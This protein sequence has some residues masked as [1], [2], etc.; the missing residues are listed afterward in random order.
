MLTDHDREQLLKDL[1]MAPTDA[2]R[3]KWTPEPFVPL[4]LP[5]KVHEAL[6]RLRAER[7][8]EEIDPVGTAK[9]RAIEAKYELPGDFAPSQEQVEDA[10]DG[11]PEDGLSADPAQR[12]EN[13]EDFQQ[14]PFWPGVAHVLRRN[15]RIAAFTEVWSDLLPL[16]EAQ[17][18]EYLVNPVIDLPGD[19][20]LRT[21]T[22]H[23]APSAVAAALPMVGLDDLKYS[24]EDRAALT[25]SVPAHVELHLEMAS[26]L[27]DK[28]RQLQNERENKAA[29]AA[30]F[31]LEM[32]QYL[33]EDRRQ[34]MDIASG[35]TVEP[36]FEA[37]RAAEAARLEAKGLTSQMRALNNIATNS[38][39]APAE[40]AERLAH[41]NAWMDQHG[42]GPQI[43]NLQGEA[44]ERAQAIREAAKVVASLNWKQQTAILTSQAD[45]LDIRA[46]A[47]QQRF[48]AH[49]ERAASAAHRAHRSLMRVHD[50]ARA[51][52]ARLI[53]ACTPAGALN[54]AHQE[55]QTR[56][57]YVTALRRAILRT[58]DAADG[59]EKV[60]GYQIPLPR[61]VV[62]AN[63]VAGG[64]AAPSNSPLPAQ[65]LYAASRWV[66][67][68]SEWMLWSR[69][70]ENRWVQVVSIRSVL[71][72][73]GWQRAA[74]EDNFL[75]TLSPAMLGAASSPRVLG[76]NLEVVPKRDTGFANLG[77][78]ARVSLP[79]EAVYS[80]GGIIHKLDQQWLADL[81][82][83]RLREPH[84][85]R[86]AP[87]VEMSDR[88]ANASP[89]GDW[90]IAIAGHA[91]DDLLLHLWL[92]EQAHD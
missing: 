2:G 26:S 12:E 8:G 58:V 38:I 89:L 88:I 55:R 84:P 75:F 15:R 23:F 17:Y 92:A 52:A 42:Y 80:N 25:A 77:L 29:A 87:A 30:L 65:V 47:A 27:L 31:S 19:I 90:K 53:L 1:R 61:E 24:I 68:A 11:N 36:V 44:K 49:V 41:V 22:L 79:S 33:A 18:A 64:Q 76:L 71:G 32:V 14:R 72:E 50:A 28:A 40:A 70:K 5:P 34:R 57:D 9:R 67:E 83:G 45:E 10:V 37:H 66:R 6:E 43:T 21:T 59:I 56:L 16:F 51:A 86:P 81:P 63:R 39:Y 35:V 54:Y 7:L 60:F 48:F 62:I 91:V 69:R 78:V 74:A 20:P 73:H 85:G 3:F 82:I 4:P 13:F 46:Q